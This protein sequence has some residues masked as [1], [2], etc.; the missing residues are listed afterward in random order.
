MTQEVDGVDVR[1]RVPPDLKARWDEML[2]ARKISH[3]AADLALKQ[4]AVAQPPLFQAM[5][6]GQIPVSPELIKL[7][8]E[9]LERM[10]SEPTFA[11][12]KLV[13]STGAPGGKKKG[14][15]GK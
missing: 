2:K 3:Q 9:S 11:T 5:I 12:T 14:A 4:W 13:T 1:T 8:G 6:F 10:A 15:G 7:V